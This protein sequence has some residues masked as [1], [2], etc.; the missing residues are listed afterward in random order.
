[1][2]ATAVSALLLAAAAAAARDTASP[3]PA[4]PT[5]ERLQKV[6]ERRLALENEIGRLRRDEKSLLG[7]VE[8]LELQVRLREQELR[9]IQ[10]TLRRTREEMETAHKRAAGLEKSLAETRPAV[11][12]RARA[13]YKLGE[14]SYLR[15][16]LSVDRPVDVFRAYRFVSSL[17][18]EDKE[19][20]ARFR[21]D[22][23][24]LQRT[25]EDLDK[26]SKDALDLRAESERRRK[27]LDGERAEKTRLLTSLVE[28][29]EMQLAYFEEL[30][31]AEGKL[32]QIVDSGSAENA[33]VP[34]AALRGSLPWPVAGKVTVGFGPRKHPRFETLTPHNGL[35]IEGLPESPVVAAHE[36]TVAHAGPFLGY[37]QMV[38]I[39]HGGKHHTVYARLAELDV[40]VG[41]RLAAGQVLGRL[42]PEEPAALYFEL[43]FQGQPVDP[44][45]WLARPEGKK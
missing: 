26:K 23:D 24:A 42:S 35:E 18:R 10:L 28:H 19:R 29:K 14:F 11:V 44:V 41:E 7:D 5:A 31:Q 33:A 6:H 2:I 32:R 30:E 43:R 25:R 15:L 17:A 20:V 4:P 40:S 34:I 37:G 21:R 27:R 1:M 38:V 16:L 9:E 3:E 22:L 8:R 12:A 13:L 39:D 45:D 36:G